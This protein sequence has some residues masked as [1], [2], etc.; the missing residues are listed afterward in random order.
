[1]KLKEFWHDLF[2]EKWIE[3]DGFI[4]GGT[5][6]PLIK[7]AFKSVCDFWCKYWQPIGAIFVI[8]GVIIAAINLYLQ[9]FR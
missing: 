5:Q 4:P 9:Y 8:M 2:N 3:G 6:P 7:F 1:M